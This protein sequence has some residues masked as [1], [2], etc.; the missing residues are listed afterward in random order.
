MQG[1]DLLVEVLGQYVDLVL[2]FAVIGKELDLGQHLVGE[3]RAHHKARVA[4]GAAQINEPSLG[5]HDQPLAVGKD[6]LVDLRL[7]LLPGVVAQRVDLD[8]AVEMAEVTD[9]RAVLH[10]AHVVDRDHVDVAGRGD[11]DVALCGGLV[12]RRDL[13]ALHRRLQRADRIDLGDHDAP[14]GA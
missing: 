3:G 7:D 9:D 5:H 4:G 1:G 6:D 13:V 14:L 12:H 10:M 2:V 8:L 11:K